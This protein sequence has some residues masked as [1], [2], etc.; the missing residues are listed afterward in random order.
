[1]LVVS[2]SREITQQVI[3]CFYQS[4]E[5]QNH[6]SCVEIACHNGPKSHVLVGSAQT[7]A[8]LESMM[9]IKPQFQAVKHQRLDTIH[10]FHSVFTKPPLKPLDELSAS[11]TWNKPI[12]PLESCTQEKSESFSHYRPSNH[13]RKPVYFADAVRRIEH[14]LGPCA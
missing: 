6:S 8:S 4:K 2:A 13:R 10:G 7:I 11:L 12:I 1:M 9:K 5:V 14:N 3:D